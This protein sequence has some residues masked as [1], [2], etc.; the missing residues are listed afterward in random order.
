[1]IADNLLNI[2][3][4]EKKTDRERQKANPHNGVFSPSNVAA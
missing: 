2:T 4:V 3:C 1:M